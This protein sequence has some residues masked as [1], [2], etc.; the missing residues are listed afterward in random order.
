MDEVDIGVFDCCIFDVISYYYSFVLCMVVENGCFV[1]DVLVYIVYNIVV[2]IDCCKVDFDDGY[3]V[4][5]WDLDMFLYLMF[6]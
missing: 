2:G 4:S 6:N 1:V 3:G 5:I